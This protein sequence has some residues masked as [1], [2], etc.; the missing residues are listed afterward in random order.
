MKT[1]AKILSIT[2]LII[3]IIWAFFGFFGAWFG[4]AVV[5]SLESTSKAANSTMDTTVMVMIKLIFSFVLVI[6]GGVLGIVGADKK[7]SRM[8][9]IILGSLVFVAGVGLFPLH[10]WA[11]A[12][13][14]VI[15][16]FLLVIAGAVTKVESIA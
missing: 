3:G 10:N 8:K 11:A 7:P 4:G 9:P 12:A 15:A 2:A 1:A 14:Y 16:G 5:A 6:L 13:L